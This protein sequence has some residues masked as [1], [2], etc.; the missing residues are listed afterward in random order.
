MPGNDLQVGVKPGQALQIMGRKMRPC[1]PG[2]SGLNLTVTKA[3]RTTQDVARCVASSFTKMD[4][5]KPE[6]RLKNYSSQRAMIQIPLYFN[7]QVIRTSST[8]CFMDD[9]FVLN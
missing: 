4:K 8:I 6:V 5:N 3:I 2:L 1:P 9:W 7:L